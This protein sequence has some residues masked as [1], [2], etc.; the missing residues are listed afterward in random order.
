M[1]RPFALYMHTTSLPNIDGELQSMPLNFKL[2]MEARA[3]HTSQ[4][5]IRFQEGID[6]TDQLGASPS[7][8]N[9]AMGRLNTVKGSAF[10]G[11]MR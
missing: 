1:T 9:S 7:T 6:S 5:M 11:A 8:S 2:P 4:A 3:E 10:A